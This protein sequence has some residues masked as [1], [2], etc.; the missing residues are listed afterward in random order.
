VTT[1]DVVYVD[2]RSYGAAWYASLDLADKDHKTY[3]FE[4]RYLDWIGNRHKKIWVIADLLLEEYQVQTLWVK[5]WGSNKILDVDT[6]VLM[7]HNFVIIHPEVLSND[8]RDAVLDKCRDMA[9]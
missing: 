7:D 3:V 1:G 9:N 8:N 6:M 2:L 4:Y 5:Q